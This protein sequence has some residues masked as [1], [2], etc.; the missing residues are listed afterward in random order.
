MAP[1]INTLVEQT[2][3]ETVCRN[4]EGTIERIEDLMVHPL[5]SSEDRHRI[6]DIMGDL[7]Q[8]MTLINGARRRL[9]VLADAASAPGE[10]AQ[11]P[12]TAA[13][14]PAPPPASGP[15]SASPAAADPRVDAIL[16]SIVQWNRRS[17]GEHSQATTATCPLCT[18]YYTESDTS[19][20]C[21][22]CPVYHRTELWG[23]RGTP[24]GRYNDQRALAIT[25]SPRE[26]VLLSRDDIELRNIALQEVN[27]LRSLLP[28][29]HPDYRAP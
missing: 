19:T 17:S 2:T 24:V 23:C 20:L 7:H 27:F 14:A 8:S 9:A 10:P 21:Q 18:L 1:A 29:N 5:V 4:I 22:N 11:A 12:Q 25:R 16:A 6:L 15:S 3:L 13:P 26:N 28:T